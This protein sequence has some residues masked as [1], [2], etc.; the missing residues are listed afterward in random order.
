MNN[1]LLH[2]T[3]KTNLGK[4]LTSQT[5]QFSFLSGNGLSRPGRPRQAGIGNAT[6]WLP[7]YSLLAA[8]LTRQQFQAVHSRYHPPEFRGMVVF[9][10][11]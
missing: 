1:E 3:L 10:S 7:E 2:K 5:L 4:N 9:C 11:Q 8:T 6:L